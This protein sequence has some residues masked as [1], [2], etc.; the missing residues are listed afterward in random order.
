MGYVSFFC[1]FLVIS[2]FLGDLFF[3]FSSV[4][5]PGLLGIIYGLFY[6]FEAKNQAGN[7]TDWDLVSLLGENGALCFLCC[8][9]VLRGVLWWC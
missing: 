4:T 3:F 9:D 6:G 5:I 7:M 8:P 1:F 2:V